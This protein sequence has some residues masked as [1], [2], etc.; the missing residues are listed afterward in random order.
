MASP[1]GLIADIGATNAR[2]ALADEKEIYHQKI[3]ACADYPTIVDAAQAYLAG[4]EKNMKPEHGVFAVAG[5]VS[6]D[7]FEMTNHGW[8]FSVNETAKALELS[9]LALMNDFKAVALGVPHL[10]PDH[11]R[12]IG[13]DQKPQTG[14]TIGIIGPGTGLGVASLFWDGMRYLPNPCEGGHVTMAAKTQR[15]FDIFRTLRYKYRHVSAERVCSG[16]GLYNIYQAIKVLDGRDD[17][18][19][20][21]PEQIAECA[22]NKTCTVCEESMDKML[23]FLGTI[24]GNLALTLGA[25]GGVYIAGG[26]PVKL[27]EA[28]FSSRFRGEFE[29]KGRYEGYLSEIPTY[30]ITHPNIAFA[31]LQS[32]I[33]EKI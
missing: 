6:G 23:G 11:I 12:Q 15:E 26:I 24:A 31:G 13:G 21:T 10:K 32:Y 22:L 4:V 30:L 5:P 2:F 29:A 25:S 27:G 3:L 14:G 9:D 33:A 1:V 18:P 20:R 17:I 28:F 7:Y 8:A 16:K 19:D